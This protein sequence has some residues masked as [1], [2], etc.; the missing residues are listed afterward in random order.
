MRERGTDGSVKEVAA[1]ATDAATPL[2]LP[3]GGMLT[4]Q[5]MLGLQR[6]AGNRAAVAML[7]REP[8]ATEAGGKLQTGSSGSPVI[9][10]QM[11][12]NQLDEVKTELA[13]DGIYGPI[14]TSAVRQF[15]SAHAP[16]KANGV[17]D[18]DTQAA[19]AEA[20]TEDQ[21]PTEIARKL[22]ALGSKAF[23]RH[24][25]GHAYAFFTRAGELA[26]RPGIVFS[27]A[28]ALRRLGARR[29]EA[30][31]LYE[32]YLATGQGTR[33]ADAEAAL[34]ELR[35]PEATG[36]EDIDNATAKGIFNHGAA[37]FEAHDYAH[38][39]DEFTRAGELSD[40]PGILFSRAQA[41]RK[42]GGRREEAIALYEQ[43]LAT[44]QGTRE[45]DAQAALAELRT[46]EKTG[47]E[48][49]DNA[50][51]KGIF[52][53]GAADFE[54]GDYAHAYD[55]FT[56]AGEVEDRPG[57]LF[58]RAQ[59]L[60]KLGGREAEAMALYQQYIDLGEGTRLADAEQM[61]ELLR[62]H[63]AAPN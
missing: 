45:K 57:I 31:A 16:L 8:T 10:L 55:E 36:D 34:A 17:A 7:A 42:L 18:V 3:A 1:E 32:Q 21:D 53:K 43:Y 48:D 30:I 56:R 35:T 20:M 12:L 47:D 39:Y 24:Q 14:T 2:R 46:P 37:L 58:S 63:G 62:T 61:L 23:D 38:A 54:A 49:V 5:G 22:F 19:I 9:D 41:L 60:R 27:R 50:T 52:N 6:H 44:G 4:P 25:F 11:R 59:A 15:Q 33:V 13:V 51:A 40:R 28:Q 29:E 26:D